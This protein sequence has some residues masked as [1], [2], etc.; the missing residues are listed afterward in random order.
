MQCLTDWKVPMTH[1]Y[2]AIALR[3]VERV[4]C[5]VGFPVDCVKSFFCPSVTLCEIRLDVYT[6]G[7]KAKCLGYLLCDQFFVNDQLAFGSWKEQD[8]GA[9]WL[10]LLKVFHCEYSHFHIQSCLDG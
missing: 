2:Q 9:F 5:S 7:F 8:H 1:F 6:A 4:T 10:L 3:L